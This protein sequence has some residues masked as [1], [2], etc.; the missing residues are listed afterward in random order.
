[1]LPTLLVVTATEFPRAILSPSSDFVLRGGILEA[2]EVE[3]EEVGGVNDD[4][5]FEYGEGSWPTLLLL[6]LLIVDILLECDVV[7]LEE[8][9]RFG[10]AAVRDGI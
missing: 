7:V 10:V 3:D 9:R 5:G 2:Y 6:L 4:D 1:M 8:S